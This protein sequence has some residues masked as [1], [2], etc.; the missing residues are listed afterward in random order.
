[1]LSQTNLPCKVILLPQL[2]VCT[3]VSHSHREAVSPTGGPSSRCEEL[4][5]FLKKISLC[6]RSTSEKSYRDI[7]TTVIDCHITTLRE[8]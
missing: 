6:E 8:T 3:C 5:L 7:V 1:M 4:L 2:L